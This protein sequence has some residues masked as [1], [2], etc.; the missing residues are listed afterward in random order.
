[1]AVMMS[2]ENFMMKAIEAEV[3]HE[4]S[5]II[6]EEIKLAQEK[7]AQ[8]TRGAL[9]TMALKLLR[10]YDVQR[11][12]ENLVITVKKDIGMPKPEG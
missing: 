11:S 7:V 9:D 4:I 3:R 1:M 6:E 8:R 12:G 2:D 10:Y 5:R